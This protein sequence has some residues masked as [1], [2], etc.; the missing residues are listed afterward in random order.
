MP[1]RVADVSDPLRR[2]QQLHP[3]MLLF[4]RQEQCS[5]G[6]RATR[7]GREECCK[8]S[9]RRRNADASQQTVP[10]DNMRCRARVRCSNLLRSTCDRC[11]RPLVDQPNIATPLRSGVAHPDTLS[12]SQERRRG[13]RGEDGEASRGRRG[14]DGE[15]RAARRGRRGEGPEQARHT[16]PCFWS[17]HSWVLAFSIDCGGVSAGPARPQRSLQNRNR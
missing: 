13:R 10:C 3:S 15:A 5:H 4:H 1:R 11:D 16:R 7:E 6:E 8:P 17:W 9:S 12:C 14:E 2:E